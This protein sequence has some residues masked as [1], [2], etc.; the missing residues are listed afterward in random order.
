MKNLHFTIK[1]ALVLASACLLLNACTGILDVEPEEVVTAEHMY[2]DKNDADAMIKGI[3]GKVVRLSEQYVI[4]NELRA[5]LMDVTDNADYELQ[6]INNHNAT[7][8]NRYVDPLPF[9][10]VINQCNDALKNFDLMYDELKLL[11]EDYL[12]RS[13]DIGILRSWIY[14]NLVI[15]F[16]EVPYI[17]DPVESI[18]SIAYIKAN[19]PSLDIETMIDTL[20]AYVESIPYHDRYTDSELTTTISGYPMQFLYIDKMFFLGDLYLWNQQYLEAASIYKNLMEYDL[21]RTNYDSYKIPRTFDPYNVDKYN[22]NYYRYYYWDINSTLNHWPLMFSTNPDADFYNEWIWVMKFDDTYAPQNP[23][24]DLCSRKHGNYM[25]QPSKSII[26]LWNDQKQ[27]NGFM[28][29]FR[30]NT[31]SYET[32][33]S[34]QYPEITK[35]TAE[36]DISSPFEKSGKFMLMRAA[37]LHLRY[38]EAANRDNEH[39]IAYH[40]VNNGISNYSPIPEDATDVSQYQ[41]TLKPFPYDFDALSSQ[42]YHIPSMHRGLWYRNS[43]IRS[44]VYLENVTLD[45]SKDSTIAIEDMILDEAAMEMAFEGNRWGDLVRIALRRNDPAFLAD[46]IYEKLKKNNNPNAET[47]RQKLMTQENWFLPLTQ[48]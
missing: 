12:Q 23:F 9:Y 8:K 31:G 30:G 10:E 13:A 4:L 24:F 20:V 41:R 7:A 16:G 5:D 6:E 11:E 14:L 44:R 26:S 33:E 45:A 47:I 25:L 29:D 43:G 15:H 1:Q 40:L 48:E 17:T 28:G 22:S 46:R 32:D 42:S 18:E 2:R 27:Q 37:L 38:S 35:Y 21:G 39:K 3:Y 34:G 19:A 36:F